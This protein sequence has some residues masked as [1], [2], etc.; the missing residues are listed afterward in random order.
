MTY[1]MRVEHRDGTT[2]APSLNFV[3]HIDEFGRMP[4]LEFGT[5]RDSALDAGLQ[6]ADDEVYL[7]DDGVK[8]EGG[9]LR[10]TRTQRAKTKLYMDGF[11]QYA[12]DA[13]RGPT[14]ETLTGTDKAIVEGAVDDVPQLTKG[15]INQTATD[16]LI[17]AN[18]ASPARVI[19]QVRNVAAGEIR[20]NVDKSVDYVDEV[21]ADKTGTVLSPSRGNFHVLSADKRTGEG[22][23]HL[24]CLGM[25]SGDA[26]KETEAIASQYN[27]SDDR[28]VWATYEDTEIIDQSTLDNVCQIVADEMYDGR[29][30]VKGWVYG[31]AVDVGDK[32]HVEYPPKNIDRDLSVIK[33]VR[34]IDVH[35]ERYKVTLANQRFVEGE[36]DKKIRE[37]VGKYVRG[38]IRSGLGQYDDIGNAP[39]YTGEAGYLVWVTGDGPT[40]PSGVYTYRPNE[41]YEQVSTVDDFRWHQ[42]EYGD[43]ADGDKT[44]SSNETLSGVKFY[45]TFDVQSGNT[46]TVAQG[47]NLIVYADDIIVDGTINGFGGADGGIGGAGGK[48]VDNISTSVDEMNGEAGPVG[49]YSPTA[50]GG[51]GGEGGSDP[52]NQDGGD[53]GAG[54][55]APTSEENRL[56][57]RTGT[58]V[59]NIAGVVDLSVRAGA[60][61]GGGGGAS[62][63]GGG[64]DNDGGSPG[65][66]VGGGGGGAI[67]SNDGSTNG[68]D[69]GAGGAA[70]IL[71]ANTIRGTGEVDVR[72]GGGDPPNNTGGTDNTGGG[73]GGGGSGGAIIMIAD[74]LQEW[75]SRT[76]DVAAGG[77]FNPAG[78]GQGVGGAGADGEQGFRYGFDRDARTTFG[79][80]V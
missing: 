12:V 27:A 79:G 65:S 40:T 36:R 19:R 34:I 3:R 15:T 64:G 55:S 80:M 42:Y 23:T 67:T 22:A 61:G 17:V 32:F 1:T 14:N 5:D 13:P 24:K 46:V 31:E 59:P 9:L 6:E 60:G 54:G 8:D 28:E 52:S 68:G 18:Y 69:G 7:M 41:G 25:G 51:S 16:L 26:Q 75:S 73:G 76:H 72:G 78:S 66:A 50:A 35:G 63:T 37:D 45:N 71:M 49:G 56:Y 38:E 39:A 20:Y 29:V 62:D 10:D 77:G 58:P 11:E 70:V 21:G 44:V 48:G 30:Q 57:H 2:A 47:E 33:A 53:G 74:D 43:L 4:Q